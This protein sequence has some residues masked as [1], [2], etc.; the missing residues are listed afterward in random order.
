LPQI[1]SGY[2][3]VVQ[4]NISLR[5]KLTET[6]YFLVVKSN[7]G[8]VTDKGPVYKFLRVYFF[9]ILAQNPKGLTFGFT[10]ERK[11]AAKID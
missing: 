1:Q 11:F 6:P 2:P 10:E 4:K 7:F 5:Q 9:Q 3:L 8:L